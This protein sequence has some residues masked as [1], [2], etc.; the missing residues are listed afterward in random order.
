MDTVSP[1]TRQTNRFCIKCKHHLTDTESWQ[2]HEESEQHNMSKRPSWDEYFFN[3]ARE[4]STRASC[5]RASVGA[6]IVSNSHRILS[7]GYNGAPPGVDDCLLL[8]CDIVDNHCQRALH[9][10]VNAIAHAANH[11]VSIKNSILYVY[12][13]SICR[14]CNKVVLAA[15][16]REV[17][18]KPLSTDMPLDSP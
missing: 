15:G 12:G 7:T 4:V 17:K 6:V 2:T 16:I 3:I 14:E 10:E 11:G 9:A 8:G 5:P 1:I 18:V 13:K